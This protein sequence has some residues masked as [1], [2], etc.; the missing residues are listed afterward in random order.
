MHVGSS[1]SSA[2]YS[3]PSQL[4]ST[5]PADQALDP[6]AKAPSSATDETSGAGKESPEQA[7]ARTEAELLE[8][9]QKQIA[10]LAARDREVRAHEQAHAGVGG[11]HTGGASYTYTRGPDGKRY[12][13]DGEVSVDTSA[14]PGDPAATLT[15][16]DI[17]RRAA[18]AP[19]EPS[20]QDL[21]VAAQAQ[22]TA[23]QARAELAEQRRTEATEAAEARKAE[24]A[25]KDEVEQATASA[26]DAVAAS[27]ESAIDA[28]PANVTALDT[29]RS[30]SRTSN[31]SPQ[32][33]LRA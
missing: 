31:D 25:E 33:D 24:K 18:L 19:A 4:R 6:V 16:M 30:F 14:V 29:Y 5:G 17:V 7:K 22:A 13:T 21:R 9:E 3:Y 8:A 23:A 11:A 15:K 10:D 1:V 2:A 32:L 28:R 26:D 20:S 27:S 12:A